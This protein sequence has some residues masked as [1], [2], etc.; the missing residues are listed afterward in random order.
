M[1]RYLA[2]ALLAGCAANPAAVNVRTYLCE[3]GR[4]AVV[5]FSGDVARVRLAND[6][7]ELR[8]VPSAS[9]VRYSGARATLHTKGDEALLT[10]DGR[11]LGPCQ[12]AKPQN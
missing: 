11:E 9:G 10:L 2:A 7:L 6:Q 4:V 1:T 12:E 8:R 5:S 3:E